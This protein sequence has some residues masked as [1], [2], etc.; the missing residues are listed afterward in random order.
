MTGDLQ[1]GIWKYLAVPF[2]LVGMFDGGAGSCDAQDAAFL[3]VKFHTPRLFHI[4]Q[5]GEIFLRC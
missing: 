3:R 4:R 5:T 1:P 2:K